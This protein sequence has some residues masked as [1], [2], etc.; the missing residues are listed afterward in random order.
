[1]DGAIVSKNNNALEKDALCVWFTEKSYTQLFD[2][3]HRQLEIAKTRNIDIS[4]CLIPEIK[5]PPKQVSM[6][7]LDGIHLISDSITKYN[8]CVKKLLDSH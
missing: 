2:T 8:A 4:S 6:K 1:M 7:V 3:V 5:T